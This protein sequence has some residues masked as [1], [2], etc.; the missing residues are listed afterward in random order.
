[1]AAVLN[2]SELFVRIYLLGADLQGQ[3]YSLFYTCE[4]S[5]LV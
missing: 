2:S 4:F 5:I 1:M 3:Q